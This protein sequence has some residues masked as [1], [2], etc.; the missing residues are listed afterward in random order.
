MVATDLAVGPRSVLV[1]G[2]EALNVL[3]NVVFNANK[4]VRCIE[5]THR[6]MVETPMEIWIIFET[7]LGILAKP[8]SFKGIS[9][10]TNQTLTISAEVLKVLGLSLYESDEVVK[11]R[12]SVKKP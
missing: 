9:A 12:A 8:M 6:A 7:E 10:G 2:A 3:A 11:I 5:V 1:D 4:T